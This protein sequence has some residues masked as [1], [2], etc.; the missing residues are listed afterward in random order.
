MDEGGGLF[1]GPMGIKVICNFVVIGHKRS[2]AAH[3]TQKLFIIT[4]IA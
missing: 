2:M 4:H 3:C 1:D